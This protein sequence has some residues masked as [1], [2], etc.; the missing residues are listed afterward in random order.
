M[1]TDRMNKYIN[2]LLKFLRLKHLIEPSHLVT[3]IYT[4]Y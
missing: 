1:E 3:Q 2:D 4:M